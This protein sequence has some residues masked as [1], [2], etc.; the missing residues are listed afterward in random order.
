MNKFVESG[1]ESAY[2]MRVDGQLIEF[3]TQN[4]RSLRDEQVL[5][6]VAASEGHPGLIHPEGLSETLLPVAA[7]YGANASGKSNVLDALA[8]MAKAV[9][10]SQRTWQPDL[11]IPRHPHLLLTTDD[12][13]LP[14]MFAV[15]M[16]VSGVRY[17]FGFAVTDDAVV[18]EWL[19][20]WPSGRKQEWYSRD[21]RSFDF[22]RNLSGENK[23][24]EAL[25]RPNSLFLSAAAQ[26]NHPQL[27][28]IYQWFSKRL[29][30]LGFSGSTSTDL[31]LRGAFRWWEQFSEKNLTLPNILPDLDRRRGQVRSLL[32]SSDLGIEDFMVEEDRS[33]GSRGHQGDTNPRRPQLTFAH[34]N[35]ANQMRVWF[36][37]EQESTGTQV[38]VS[39]LP[40]LLHILEEGGLLAIDELN[41]LHPTLALA[42]VRLFQDP[43]KTPRGAQLLF[44]THE[45]TLLGN[46]L[47]D[48]PPLRRDQVW[49]TEKDRDGAT[50]LYPLTDFSPRP[51]ENLQ[52]G[53]LQGRYGA[54]PFIGALDLATKSESDAT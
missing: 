34:E 33:P 37:L 25:T 49:L 1:I 13:S 41:S 16:M 21:G 2:P 14:S 38:L 26:N 19:N 3:R 28:P 52:R 24:I 17:E 15:Q 10:F 31:R 40:H 50:H 23:A 12:E 53:Y 47:S 4:H 29:R 6:L 51:T 22:G 18:E 32:T 11:G 39:I 43:A 30:V 54:I 48:P 36:E 9:A 45:S 35:K 7:I 42:I 27:T 5:S 46:L 20:A 8:F 44:N